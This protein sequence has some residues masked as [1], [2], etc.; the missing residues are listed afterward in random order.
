MLKKR[1]DWRMKRRTRKE[2]EASFDARPAIP[3]AEILLQWEHLK[4]RKSST[5]NTPEMADVPAPAWCPPEKSS[6]GAQLPQQLLSCH[7]HVQKPKACSAHSQDVRE[8]SDC[9]RTLTNKA[10]WCGGRITQPDGGSS[11][12][13]R[14]NTHFE[15][16]LKNMTLVELHFPLNL[17]I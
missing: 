2:R 6:T 5:F 13:M 9:W 15:L 14:K 1:C 11:W 12:V 8:C 10:V 16:K 7:R 4:G 3:Q 17:N